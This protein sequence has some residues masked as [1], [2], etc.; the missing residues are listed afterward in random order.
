MPTIDGKVK[1][2]VPSG[3]QTGTVFRLRNKGIKSLRGSGKGD[4]YVR[5]KIEVPKKLSEKQ[6]DLLEQFA[7]EMGEKQESDKK[8]FFGKMKDAF[9]DN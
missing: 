4:Q 7:A 3:T 9:K 5:V 6:R 8:G 2:E 1:Y